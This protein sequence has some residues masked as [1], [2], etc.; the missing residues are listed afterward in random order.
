[1]KTVDETMGCVFKYR[2][3]LHHLQEEIAGRRLDLGQLLKQSAGFQ[4]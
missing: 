3:D 2:E 4:A 1:D